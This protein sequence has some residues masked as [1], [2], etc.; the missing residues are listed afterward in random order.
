MT[1]LTLL[2]LAAIVLVGM[3]LALSQFCMV[4][5]VLGVREGS[6]SAARCVLAISLAISLSLQLLALLQGGESRPSYAPAPQVLWGGLL[7]GVAARRNGGCYVGT[8]NELCC[9]QGRRLL[10]VAGWILAAALLR[11][12]PLPAHHQRPAEVGL[13]ITALTALLAVLGWQARRRRQI[14]CPN[15][16]IAGLSGGR[17]WLLMLSTGVLMG[18]LQ[19]SSWPWD[20]SLLARALGMSLVLH[21][22]PPLSAACALLLPLGMLVVQWRRHQFEPR[23]PLVADLPLLLWGTLMGLGTSWGM[24][25]NDTYLFRSLPVGSLHAAAGLAAMALGIVLPLPEAWLAARWRRA[26]ASQRRT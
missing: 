21:R 19:H 22:P 3:A 17:A 4:R 25:A 26:T 12:P 10:T 24:G 8:L 18:L 1:T 16:A 9:G 15:P 13:V 23:Q 2:S 20:P 6:V 7:F 5:A 14:F 11:L